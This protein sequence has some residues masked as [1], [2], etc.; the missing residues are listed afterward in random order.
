MN[1]GFSYVGFFY[2]VMLFVPNLFWTKNKPEN[3]DEQVK[4][5]NKILR[6]LESAGQVLVSGIVLIFKD[7]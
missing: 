2:L 1:F 4:N 5:E 6:I 3:Y 7:F